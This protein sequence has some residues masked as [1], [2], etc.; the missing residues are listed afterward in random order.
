[1]QRNQESSI[2]KVLSNP[3]DNLLQSL[4]SF[5]LMPVGHKA[6]CAW[7]FP[8][9]IEHIALLSKMKDFKVKKMVTQRR[10]E[11]SKAVGIDLQFEGQTIKFGIAPD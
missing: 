1:M 9:T 3:Y 5:E 8:N 7:K 2:Q 10:K 11:D 4:T 6:N